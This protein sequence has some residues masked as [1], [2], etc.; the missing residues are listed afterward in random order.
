M[1][2]NMIISLVTSAVVGSIVLWL[3]AF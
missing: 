1:D 2:R 3:I